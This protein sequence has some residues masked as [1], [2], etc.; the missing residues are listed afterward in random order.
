MGKY[1]NYDKLV[2]NYMKNPL[3]NSKLIV[4]A[5]YNGFYY[6]CPNPKDIVTCELLNH[7]YNEGYYISYQ[8]FP[9]SEEY[10]NDKTNWN[11]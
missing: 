2:Q 10:Y 3:L 8:S 9:I 4:K 5:Y 7:Q 6:V 1:L 11:P